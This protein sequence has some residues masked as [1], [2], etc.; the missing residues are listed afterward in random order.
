MILRLTKQFTFEM[1]HCLTGYDGPCQNLH[2]HSYRLEVTVEGEPERDKN[3][4][5][6]GM[7]IDFR[8]LKNIVNEVI[9]SKFDH[10]V[11]L[12]DA[13]AEEVRDAL[14]RH[15][16]KVWIFAF[17]PTTENLLME[18]SRCL[19]DAFPKGAKLYSIRLQ[20]TENSWAELI[21]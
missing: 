1:A 8:E 4:A 13:V 18:F 7:V 5:K 14:Q 19:M 21:L 12:S 15:F 17:Q 3:S 2:G 16:D 9:V 11:V 6:Q 20:E 10:S